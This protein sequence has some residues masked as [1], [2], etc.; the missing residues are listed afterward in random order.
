MYIYIYI[1]THIY[2]HTHVSIHKYML[3]I[4]IDAIIDLGLGP[5][6]FFLAKSFREIL[7]IGGACLCVWGG[8]IS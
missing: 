2:I 4:Y 8:C 1:Y 5:A 7:G 6:R 3:H